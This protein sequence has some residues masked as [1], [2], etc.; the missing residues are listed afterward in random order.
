MAGRISTNQIFDRATSNV[1]AARE[2]EAV[3]SEKAA[4]GKELVRPSQDPAGYMISTALKDDL[5]ALET[6]VKNA[7]AAMKVLD[8]TESIFSGLQDTFQRAYELAVAAA[9]EGVSAEQRKFTYS[10]VETLYDSAIQALNTRYG[11]RSLLAGHKSDKPAFDANGKFL[12]DGGQIEIEIARDMRIPINISAQR[13]VLGQGIKDGLNIL[14][15]LKRLIIGLKTNNT[16]LVQGTLEDFGRV[17]AQIS[18]VR[19]EIGSRNAQIE[20]AINTQEQVKV[21]SISSIS[22]IEDADAVK[23]FSDLSRDQTVLKAAISTSNK[24]LS[25]NPTDIFYK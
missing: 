17:N 10:E 25:E 18:L 19:G 7:N 24:I 1:G 9:G 11:S 12:G 22:Q 3:S 8:M 4:T 15:P 16:Q 21:D 23:V 20:R 14:D 2:K 6:T 13:A 5:S